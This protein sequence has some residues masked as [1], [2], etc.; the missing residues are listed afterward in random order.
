MILTPL[1]LFFPR[2][3]AAD[4]VEL[5]ETWFRYLHDVLPLS[6]PLEVQP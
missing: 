3:Y 2:A 6:L 5:G 1:A 4:C